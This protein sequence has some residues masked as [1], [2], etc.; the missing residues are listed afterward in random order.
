MA[1]TM[2]GVVIFGQ[3]LLQLYMVVHGYLTMVFVGNLVQ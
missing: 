2:C 3:P 1:M